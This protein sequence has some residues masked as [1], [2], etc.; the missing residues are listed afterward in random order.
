MGIVESENKKAGCQNRLSEITGQ[1]KR[2]AFRQ[3][4]KLTAIWRRGWDSNPRYVAVSLVFKT[5]IGLFY[6]I[7]GPFDSLLFSFH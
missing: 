6:G 1:Q 4:L 3:T 2:S 7:Y 5:N